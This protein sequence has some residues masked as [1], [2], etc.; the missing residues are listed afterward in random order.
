MTPRPLSNLPTVLEGDI[1][2]VIEATAHSRCKFKYSA[3]L[4]AFVLHSLLP[5]GTSF[6]HAFGFVP[7][8]LGDDGDPLDIVVLA[9]EPPPVATVVP[10]VIVGILQAEQTEDGKTVRNDRLL[11]VAAHSERFGDCRRLKDIR[12]TLLERIAEFFAFYHAE[13]GKSFEPLGWKGRK[14]AQ[15][16]L[17][18]GRRQFGRAGS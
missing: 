2:A 6:P 15:Q 9:D 18:R 1:L 16:A 11:G 5:V 8:T 14:A 13:Q 12:R 17:E 3:A 7:S 10:C 4:D